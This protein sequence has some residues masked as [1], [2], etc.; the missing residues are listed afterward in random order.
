[1]L[2]MILILAAAAIATCG[3]AIIIAG[4][5]PPRSPVRA[6]PRRRPF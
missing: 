5:L 2:T 1:M 4:V 3:V 6:A